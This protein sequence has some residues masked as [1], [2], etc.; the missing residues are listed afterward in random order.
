[1]YHQQDEPWAVA[2]RVEGLSEVRLCRDPDSE[3]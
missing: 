3:G 1:M 2:A